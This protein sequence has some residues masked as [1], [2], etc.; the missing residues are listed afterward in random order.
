MPSEAIN[1]EHLKNLFMEKRRALEAKHRE[2]LAMMSQESKELELWAKTLGELQSVLPRLLDGQLNTPAPIETSKP[3][4][5][6]ISKEI[7]LFLVECPVEFSAADVLHWIKGKGFKTSK[8]TYNTI[9]STLRARVDKGLL[10]KVG[11]KF[12]RKGE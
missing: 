5:V 6:P 8:S 3:A 12:K 4:K 11:S 2:A 9:H 7:D 10:E 1:V